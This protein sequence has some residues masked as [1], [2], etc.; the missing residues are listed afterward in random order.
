MRSL[1]KPI[2]WL[3]LSLLAQACNN[4]PET[5]FTT[6]TDRFTNH[7]SDNYSQASDLLQADYMFVVDFSYSMSRNGD[8]DSKTELLLN[9]MQTFTE[10][11]RTEEIDYR[12]GFTNGNAHAGDASSISRAFIG[13]ALSL[14]T[15]SSLE[16]EIFGQIGTAGA[17]LNRNT[18]YLL[19]A[20]LRTLRGEATSFLRNAAQLVVVY[21]SDSEDESDKNDDITGDTSIE[22]YVSRLK[23]VKS[24]PD[25]INARS[26]TAKVADDCE[27]PSYDKAGIRIAETARLLDALPDSSSAQPKCIYR[28]FTE[29]L[30]DLA[31]SVVRPTDRFKIRG[32]PNPASIVIFENNVLVAASRYTYSSVS[33]EVV[34]AA[35]QAPAFEASLKIVYDMLFPFSEQP[36]PGSISVT[37]DGQNVPESAQNGWTLNTAENRIEF[38]GNAKPLEG[39]D[40]RINYAPL[41]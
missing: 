9:S 15:L 35:G 7:I 6:R 5:F 27:G 34:F 37:I 28:P 17:P 25:Y 20:S 12:I 16:S 29:S 3:G 40:V 23:Q 21:V 1:T 4:A 33:N 19:E 41:N 32:T 31:R 24:H 39:N 22:G 11:L 2:Y 18:N 8:N 13:P 26:L 10:A 38:N 30:T 14:D 36:R